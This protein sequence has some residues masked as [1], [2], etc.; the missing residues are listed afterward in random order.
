VRLGGLSVK[1]FCCVAAACARVKSFELNLEWNRVLHLYAF[2]G[3]EVIFLE[4]I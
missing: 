3:I 2:S 1:A 4:V